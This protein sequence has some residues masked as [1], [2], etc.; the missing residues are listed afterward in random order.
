MSAK[1][2]NWPVVTAALLS[3]NVPAV[4]NVVILTADSVFAGVSLGSLNPKSDAA[5]AYAVSSNIVTVLSVPA[6]AWFTPGTWN[7]PT[8]VAHEFDEVAY[9]LNTQNDLLSVGS[10]EMPE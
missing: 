6:G 5:I 10:M 4:G 3:V 7:P 1:L 8:V 2:T 9:S